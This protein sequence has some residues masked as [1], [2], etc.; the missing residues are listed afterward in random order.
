MAR[1]C[2][3]KPSASQGRQYRRWPTTRL[4]S[5]SREL[6]ADAAKN[7]AVQIDRAQGRGFAAARPAGGVPARKKERG[8]T[9][10]GARLRGVGIRGIPWVGGGAAARYGNARIFE[11]L[12]LTVGTVYLLTCKHDE[13]LGREL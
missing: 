10:A 5:R 9:H 1:E 4:A 7:R 6:K 8:R 2:P 13:R 11:E 12:R 3:A